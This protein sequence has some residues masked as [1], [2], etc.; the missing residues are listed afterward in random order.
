M[1]SDSEI[2][3]SDSDSCDINSPYTHKESESQMQIAAGNNQTMKV[4]ASKYTIYTKDEEVDY[5]I[6][7]QRKEET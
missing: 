7:R 4:V 1:N 2:I 6:E 3:N 5:E